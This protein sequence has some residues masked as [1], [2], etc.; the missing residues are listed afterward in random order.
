MSVKQGRFGP[1][2]N[3]GKVNA[4]LPKGTNTETL[5]LD[6]AVAALAAKAAGGGAGGRSLGEHPQGGAVTVRE[7]RFGPYVNWGKVNANNPKS[8]PIDMITLND[9]IELIAEREGK[10]ARPAKAPPK[11]AAAAKRRL[12]PRRLRP[13][14]RPPRRR[15]RRKRRPGRP[16]PRRRRRRHEGDGGESPKF[17]TIG[18]TRKPPEWCNRRR[19]GR[20]GRGRETREY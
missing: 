19:R 9:A 18:P 17:A 15:L 14:R 5:T 10:P 8:I 6:E 12:R 11:S 1:Y 2:V 7:G 4:T 13:R 16:R 3:H 20:A